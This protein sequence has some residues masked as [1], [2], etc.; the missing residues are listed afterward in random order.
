MINVVLFRAEP[1]IIHIFLARFLCRSCSDE[2][3]DNEQQNRRL[4][5]FAAKMY[6]CE[7]TYFSF[8][9]GLS[10]AVPVA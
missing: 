9:K 3:Q 5:F 4:D 10:F 7:C 8:G 6:F 1:K 2:N